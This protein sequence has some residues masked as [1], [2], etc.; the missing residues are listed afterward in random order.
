MARHTMARRRSRAMWVWRWVV[1]VLVV[2]LLLSGRLPPG[3]EQFLL[4]GL[5]SGLLIVAYDFIR[6]RNGKQGRNHSGNGRGP[7]EHT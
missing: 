5:G 7:V 1:A 4:I 6:W 2:G 3:L